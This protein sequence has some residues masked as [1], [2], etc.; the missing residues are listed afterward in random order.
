MI[1]NLIIEI[2]WSNTKPTQ[3]EIDK[4][5]SSISIK[6]KKRKEKL[7]LLNT[8]PKRKPQAQMASL[9]I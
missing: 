6:K 2:K 8:F 4:L 5:N 1:M 3:K 9:N 7:D